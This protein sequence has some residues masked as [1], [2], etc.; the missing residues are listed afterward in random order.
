MQEFADEAAS[1]NSEETPSVFEATWARQ[2]FCNAVN[3]FKEDCDSTGNDSRWLLF[4][5]RLLVP[6]V[7]GKETSDY[8]E[9]AKK[10]NFESP[11]QARNAMVGAKRGFDKA[12]HSVVQDYVLNDDLVASEIEDLHRILRNSDVL[13]EAVSGFVPLNQEL[14]L[15]QECFQS[16]QIAGI[17]EMNKQTKVWT[18][19]ELARM[20]NEILD[21]TFEKL[22]LSEACHKND[23]N[24]RSVAISHS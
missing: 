3:R 16:V 4:R 14:N 22:N 17:L 20:W 15:T 9:L 5:E 11:K 19:Q 10:C 12:L 18:D 2:V 23:P 21:T 8:V 6:V 24:L 7:S 13:D 1:E